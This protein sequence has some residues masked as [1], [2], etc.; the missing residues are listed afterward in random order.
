MLEVTVKHDSLIFGDGFALALNFQRTLRIPDDGGNYPL[1]PGLGSFPI[2]KVE[3]YKERAPGTWAER[4]GV[5]IPM[6]QREALWISFRPRYWKP[7]A[8]KIGIGKVNAVS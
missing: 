6:Y 5:F 7:N 3:E 4:G 8:V 2:C 1:P